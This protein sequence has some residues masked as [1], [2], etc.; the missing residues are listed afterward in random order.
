MTLLNP[1]LLSPPLLAAMGG[2]AELM[3]SRRAPFLTPALLLLH[4]C[5]SA[6]AA[7]PLLAQFA[8][9]RGFR[10]AALAA[11]ADALAAAVPGTD[12]QFQ[13]LTPKGATIP[14]STDM[15]VALDEAHSIAQASEEQ[16]IGREH[17]LGA[18]AESGVA[19]AS[20]L[21]RYGLTS[22]SLSG[23][24]ADLA[25]SRRLADLVQ[26]AREGESSPVYERHDLL[27]ALLSLLALAEHRHV[28]LVGENG[29]GRRSLALA[30]AAVMAAGRG[31]GDL[32]QLR[33]ISELSLIDEPEKALAAGVQDGQSGILL[34][35]GFDRFFNPVGVSGPVSKP[36]RVLQRAL[37]QARPVILGITTDSGWNERLASDPVVAENT[38]RLRVPEPSLDETVEILRIQR[39]RLEREYGVSLTDPALPRAAQM[40]KRYVVGMPLPASALAVIHR[41][42]A[43]DRMTARAGAA[44]KDASGVPGSPGSQLSAQD[45]NERS[46]V[47]DDDVAAAVSAMTGIPVSKL[48]VDERARFAHMVEALQTRI[49]G[50]TEAVMAVSRAVKIARVGLK[51]PKRPIG[52]FFFM[53]PTGVGKTELAKAL[54]EFLFADENAMVTLDMSEYQQEHTVNRLIGAP[55]GYVGFEA[56]GQLTE[57]VRARPSCIVLFDEAEKAHPR[58]LDV[59][60]Q[61]MEEGRLTDAQGR[62]ASFSEAVII[63]TSNVGSQFLSQAVITDENREQALAALNS[64]FRPEFLN[65]LDE[66]IVFTALGPV[67]LARILDL[68]LK[69]EGKMLAAQGVVLVVSDAAKQWLLGQNDHPEWGARPLRRI[70]QKNLREP[71][72]DWLLTAP[73]AS[74]STVLVEVAENALHFAFGSS[75]G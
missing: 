16:L 11:D 5:S 24:L 52:S 2:T 44:G 15:L 8:A 17:M 34:V 1:A 28:L 67:E 29:V 9:E 26:G 69:S 63:L 21:R 71:L 36:G 30:L 66:I 43:I 7:P 65:R 58:V 4:F 73:P 54:A 18:M 10:L 51:D 57:R 48:G 62:V 27:Q 23:R 53:G 49:I 19:T 55:P 41:A 37:L 74:G 60:L 64:V 12:A 20:L 13:W 33:Q 40:A 22:A 3:T 47:D 25:Q 72:A 32:S 68:L 38:Q 50:Q 39:G 75:S 31:P 59:L 14:F 56:G 70:I 42:C 35:P 6:V 46:Q 61:I 45:A